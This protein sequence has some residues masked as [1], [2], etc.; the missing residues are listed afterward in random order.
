MSTY[1][2]AAAPGYQSPYLASRQMLTPPLA[3][4]YLP[5]NP[6]PEELEAYNQG[7]GRTTHKDEM[8]LR[9]HPRAHG[10]SSS[11][12][13]KS[14]HDRSLRRDEY[15]PRPF[16]DVQAT[17]AY[18][19]RSASRGQASA[20]SSRSKSRSRAA[21]SLTHS[22]SSDDELDERPVSG[23]TTPYSV[24][25]ALW[26]DDLHD[27]SSDASI[28]PPPIIP[29]HII[30]EY[31]HAQPS[32]RRYEPTG[33][34]N[35]TDYSS[36]PLVVPTLVTPTQDDYPSVSAAELDRI[37]DEIADIDY[38][39]NNR[40][41][42]FTFP[43]TLDLTPQAPNEKPAPLPP[44]QRN[45]GL[46][47][48]RDYLEKV[49]LRLDDIQSYRDLGVRATRK[50]VVE[51]VHDQFQQLSRMEKMVRDNIHYREWKKTPRIHVTAPLPSS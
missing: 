20:Q 50:K 38:E 29:P 6:T 43:T 17:P 1:G 11:T 19:R 26:R 33:L 31:E 3:Y 44:T 47:M 37:R 25:V 51:K 16:L 18:H 4:S 34:A 7:R 35:S 41:L 46:L 42:E 13:S 8:N 14:R 45:K 21:P 30:A 22:S 27:S 39:L 36:L 12:R 48:H 9:R 10:G 24:N 2:Y 5:H 23:P 15:E 32:R 40:I 28:P 49:L